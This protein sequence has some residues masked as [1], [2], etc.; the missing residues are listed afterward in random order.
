MGSKIATIDLIE[1]DYDQI[2][3]DDLELMDLKWNAVMIVRKVKKFMLK[4]GKD[5]HEMN[6]RIGFDKLK[7]KCYKFQEFGHFAMECDKPKKKYSGPRLKIETQTTSIGTLS[8]RRRQK[9]LNQ[10]S[11]LGHK[12]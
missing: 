5:L 4:T 8:L 12:P 3:P 10:S 9:G 2:D 7:V 6:K 11:Q 1:K